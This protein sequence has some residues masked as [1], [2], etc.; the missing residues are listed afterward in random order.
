MSRSLSL[1]LPVEELFHR[2][3]PLPPHEEMMIEDLV[4]DEGSASLAA[5]EG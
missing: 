2:A 5:L 1:E 4:D 3:R